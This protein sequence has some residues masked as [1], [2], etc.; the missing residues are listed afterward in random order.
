ML[1]RGLELI[2]LIPHRN[3]TKSLKRI[4]LEARKSGDKEV[5]VA[6][7]YAMQGTPFKPKSGEYIAWKNWWLERLDE[8]DFAV[9]GFNGIRRIDLSDAFNLFPRLLRRELPGGDNTKE[10]LLRGL[11]RDAE[12]SGIEVGRALV[13]TLSLLRQDERVRYMNLFEKVFGGE[14]MSR[15]R[16]ALKPL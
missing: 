15:I 7:L 4:F 6:A 13:G 5:A 14:R 2:Q 3:F 8:D 1:L 10:V 12:E 16:I 9:A 11:Q